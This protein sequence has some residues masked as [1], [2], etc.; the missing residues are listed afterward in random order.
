MVEDG[1]RIT[2]ERGTPQGAVI[3]PLLANI[4]RHYVLDLWAHHWRK[5]AA[6]GTVIMVR[7]ADD[8]V[9]GFQHEDEAKRFL[10]A[11][12]ERLAKFGLAL[13]PDKT[14]LIEFGRW[15]ADNRKEAGQGK[16]ETFDFLGFTH[17]CGKSRRGWFNVVRLTVKTRMRTTLRVIRETLTRRRHEAVASVGQWLKRVV[18]G[19]FNYHAVPGNLK[20][21]KGF[22]CEVCRAW[23]HALMRRSQRHRLPWDRFNRLAQ[24]FI[25]SCKQVHPY[26]SQRF[27]V[28]T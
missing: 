23:R 5:H 22:R 14:R 1:R 10:A 13:H 21:L 12:R 24:K 11:M 18:Q 27:R 25:P 8:S 3:S 16:P 9:F 26:P 28:M 17:C 7:Y 19:Y 6:Q 2:S 15:A 4:Y 20:R